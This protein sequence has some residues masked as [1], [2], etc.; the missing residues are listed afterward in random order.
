MTIPADI[1]I[2]LFVML[3]FLYAWLTLRWIGDVL[4]ARRKRRREPE[5]HG[6][7]GGR[8][9]PDYEATSCPPGNPHWVMWKK[10]GE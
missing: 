9:A 7:D 6:D 1:L 10:A 4:V 3:F 8:P 2:A 5:T